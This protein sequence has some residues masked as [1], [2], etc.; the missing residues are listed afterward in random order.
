MSAAPRAAAGHLGG[1]LR[2]GRQRLYDELPRGRLD[3]R[4]E[5]GAHQPLQR[6]RRVAV[7]H[8]LSVPGLARLVGYGGRFQTWKPTVP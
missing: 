4:S 2:G 6:W 3:P 1:A 8:A 5:I 7:I